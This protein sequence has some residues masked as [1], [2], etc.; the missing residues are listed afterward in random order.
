MLGLAIYW[1]TDLVVGHQNVYSIV[2]DLVRGVS[3]SKSDAYRAFAL[4][5][6]SFV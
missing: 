5:P 6:A 2:H 3:L 4:Y 1:G